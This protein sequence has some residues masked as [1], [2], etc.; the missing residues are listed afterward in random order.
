MGETQIL[1]LI[2]ARGG[3]QR[4]PKKNI[5]PLHGRPLLSYTIEAARR[6]RRLTRV[7]VSTDA[8]PIARVATAWGAEAP[9]RRPAGLATADSTELEC[10]D[11]ALQWLQT[12]E[13][14]VPDLVVLL[15]PTSPFRRPDSIDRAVEAMLAH[16]EADSL[17]SV[18]KCSEHPYKMWTTDGLYLHPFVREAGG[19]ARQTWPYH[20]LPEVYIQ[21]ASIYIFKPST[22]IEKRSTT[23]DVVIPFVMDETESLDVNTPLDFR[24]AETVM[25]EAA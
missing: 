15:Y 13:G 4:V 20:R 11:H 6:A 17:R 12:H 2:P 16:P 3:S 14:Y 7:I 9:F 21:N 5:R 22:V 18:R 8:E 19:V 1:G 23:G 24:L 25:E 10:V